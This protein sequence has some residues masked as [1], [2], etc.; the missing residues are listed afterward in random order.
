MTEAYWTLTAEAR[1]PTSSSPD[2][3]TPMVGPL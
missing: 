2:I 3:N 1:L